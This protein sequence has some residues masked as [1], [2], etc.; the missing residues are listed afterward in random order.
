MRDG[1]EGIEVLLCTSVATSSGAGDLAASSRGGWSDIDDGWPRG[2]PRTSTTHT[3]RTSD[4]DN[5]AAWHRHHI[6]QYN[7]QLV[8]ACAHGHAHEV[9]R[10][11]HGR[12]LL[13]DRGMSSGHGTPL[14]VATDA[15]QHEVVR[16]LLKNRAD[17]NA[18]A[19]PSWRRPLAVAVRAHDLLAADLLLHYSADPNAEARKPPPDTFG[20][21]PP[22]PAMLTVAAEGGDL[23]MVQ[24]LTAWGGTPWAGDK[25]H[26]GIVSLLAHKSEKKSVVLPHR[27]GLPW[28]SPASLSIAMHCLACMGY[29]QCV[30]ASSPNSLPC[31]PP[32]S[33]VLSLS[34]PPSSRLQSLPQ[35][36]R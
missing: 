24:L 12:R 27:R 31:N 19:A 33:L 34:R 7:T 15:R 1:Y 10:L 32:P 28:R 23:P 26:G 11:L 14:Q 29:M 22:P 30:C 35:A 17:P 2:S 36:E 18:A 4:R 5:Q 13:M 9:V 3:I 20:H 25:R 16:W 6:R 8:H 21:A